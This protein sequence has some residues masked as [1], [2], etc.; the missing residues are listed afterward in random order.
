[1]I[2]ECR[3]CHTAWAATCR[4]VCPA[5]LVGAWLESP[6]LVNDKH[7]PLTAGQVH[8]DYRSVLSDALVANLPAVLEDAA[9]HGE[10]Y[11]HTVHEKYNHVTHLPLRLKTGTSFHAG[12]AG[13]ERFLE[14]LV[15]AD[16]DCDPH[17]FAD[18]REQTRRKVASGIYRPLPVCG[19][20]RCDNVAAPRA[21]RCVLHV[22]P[23]AALA[24]VSRRHGRAD[25]A[26]SPPGDG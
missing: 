14:D 26:A 11:F 17:L 2:V 20:A 1:M 13:P 7:H 21:D 24:A 9:L 22:R 18:D 5:C 12:K 6:R 16:A 8:A 15:V 4:P 3:V 19:R 25:P 10:W 23:A